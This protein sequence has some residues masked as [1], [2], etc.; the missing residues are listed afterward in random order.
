MVVVGGG[1]SL[2]WEQVKSA[3]RF[4]RIA[5]NDSFTLIP[6]ADVVCWGD[7]IWFKANRVELSTHTAPYMITWREYHRAK[8][9]PNVRQMGWQKPPPFLSTNPAIVTGSSSGLCAINIAWLM[10]ARRILL[11]GFDMKP[12]NGVNNWH[13][14]HERFRTPEKLKMVMSPQQ[15]KGRFIPEYMRAARLLEDKGV[16][17]I[18]CTP[19]SALQCFEYRAIDHVEPERESRTA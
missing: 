1:P 16:E 7:P 2:T 12:G 4:R 9:T 6:D 5:V 13:S 18:N 17:V 14:R 3:S 19:G 15:Y 8:P 11:L 10:G